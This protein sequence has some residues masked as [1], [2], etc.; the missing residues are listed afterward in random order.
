LFDFLIRYRLEG[1]TSHLLN[2]IASDSSADIRLS[3][4]VASITDE[5]GKVT[6]ITE[7]GDVFTAPVASV[8]VP[9][10]VWP[11]IQFSPPFSDAKREAGAEGVAITNVP[12]K[13]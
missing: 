10:N 5:G 3:T 11:H 8:A 1:G 6:V 13:S 4:S 2:A 12:A 7:A 9:V